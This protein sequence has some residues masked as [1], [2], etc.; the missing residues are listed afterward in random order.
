MQSIV[1]ESTIEVKTAIVKLKKDWIEDRNTRR[2]KRVDVAISDRIRPSYHNRSFMGMVA[3]RS[4]QIKQF[5]MVFTE[6]HFKGKEITEKQPDGSIKTTPFTFEEGMRLLF[7]NP[8]FTE[9]FG[10]RKACLKVAVSNKETMSWLIKE[11]LVKPEW[12]GNKQEFLALTKGGQDE[13]FLKVLEES[14]RKAPPPQQLPTAGAGIAGAKF[15]QEAQLEAGL[16]EQEKEVEDNLAAL[17]SEENNSELNQETVDPELN[18]EELE[19]DT[20][21]LKPKASAKKK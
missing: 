17:Q 20:E 3:G 4:S 1:M 6:E 11:G 18:L 14:T 13:E 16:N 19:P 8:S 9:I 7:S 2:M 5:T 12:I 15:L 10:T 21:V